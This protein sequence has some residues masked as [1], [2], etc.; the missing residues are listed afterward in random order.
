LPFKLN[1]YRYVMVYHEHK[2]ENDEVGLYK[3]KSNAVVDPDV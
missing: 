2:L 1:L 3:R